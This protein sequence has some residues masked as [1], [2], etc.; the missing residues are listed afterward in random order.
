[1]PVTFTH[2]WHLAD[3]PKPFC[4]CISIVSKTWFPRSVF[5]TWL[6]IEIRLLSIQIILTPARIQDLAFSLSGVMVLYYTKVAPFEPPLPQSTAKGMSANT[7]DLCEICFFFSTTLQIFSWLTLCSAPEWL[8]VLHCWLK[9]LCKA[10]A[11]TGVKD[12]N[13]NER[14]VRSL[15]LLGE[16]AHDVQ[17]QRCHF[18][19]FLSVNS[20]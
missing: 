7:T 11:H 18:W 12:N 9:C 8:V 19:H 1:M 10:S 5:M 6:V 2:K 17:H 20:Y 14:Q 3:I 15:M 16:F 4:R 13:L